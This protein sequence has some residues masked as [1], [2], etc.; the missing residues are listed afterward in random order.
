MCVGC[1]AAEGRALEE[2]ETDIQCQVDADVEYDALN[3]DMT[4]AYEPRSAF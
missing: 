1:Y 4:M 3:A 2:L